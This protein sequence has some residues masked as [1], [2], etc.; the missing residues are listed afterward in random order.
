[1]NFSS[2]D[3]V[4]VAIFLNDVGI[5]DD[6]CEIFEGADMHEHVIPHLPCVPFKLQNM[7]LMDKVIWR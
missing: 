7:R 6:V 1:M 2:K 3:P 4:E 5:T